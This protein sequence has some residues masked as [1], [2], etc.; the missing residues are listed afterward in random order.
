MKCS[1][2]PNCAQVMAEV[3]RALSREEGHGNLDS[4]LALSL[5]AELR[6][7]AEV[8]D[9]ASAWHVLLSDV[10]PSTS[11]SRSTMFH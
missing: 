3:Q 9:P 10:K 1:G 4:G 6:Q 5:L 7:R 2:G 11:D 8:T